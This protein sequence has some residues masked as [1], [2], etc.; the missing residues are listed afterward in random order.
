MTRE[1]AL[2]PTLEVEETIDD[3]GERGVR[4]CP[5][6]PDQL[7][8]FAALPEE[9]QLTLFRVQVMPWQPSDLDLPQVSG[10]RVLVADGIRFVPDFPFEPGIRYRATFDPA[11]LDWFGHPP[12][13]ITDFL[14][15][16]DRIAPAPEVTGV[17]PAADELPE[18]LLRIY[19]E[20]S[21]PMRRGD[22]R[23][24][25]ILTD[26]DGVPV[27]DAL[28]NAPV[29]LWAPDMRRLTILLDPGRLKRGVGPNR[30]LGPPLVVGR[31]Y[32][33]AIGAALTALDG[34]RLAA[35]FVKGF[36]TSAPV[37][38]SL[39]PDDWVLDIPAAGGRAPL[40][41]I[42]PHPM[43]HALLAGGISIARLGGGSVD[44]QIS[45]ADD[46]R[47]W[48][49]TPSS[50]WISGSYRLDLD[51]DLEDVCG[52]G[53]AGAFD[54]PLRASDDLNVEDAARSLAFNVR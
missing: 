15:A 1:T 31:E 7:A 18:N 6:P 38:T 12:L 20:F 11:S 13:L 48:R 28:Y 2:P 46:D 53:L 21:Q 42:F 5:L 26:S 51:S 45:T 9:A 54:R 14:T 39:S 4:A 35:P 22:A 44:G 40:A 43:D 49:F 23:T 33:L 25:V 3:Q 29:E 16:E 36:R 50:C 8:A 52:N 37:R 19:V 27:E 17:F 47:T 30:A 32:I 10:R 34:Q 41:L 24:A